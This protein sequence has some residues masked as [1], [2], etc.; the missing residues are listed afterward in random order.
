MNR[1]S[2]LATAFALVAGLACQVAPAAAAAADE[3]SPAEII[4]LVDKAQGD[5]KDLTTDSK[6]VVMEPGATSGREYR[7]VTIS[8]GNEKR[9]VRFLE[10]GDVKGMGMLI[11]GRDTMY[12]LLP[13]FGNRIRRLGTHVKNQGF[14][15]SDVST[16]DMAGGTLADVYD[17]KVVSGSENG[18][19]EW[20]LELTVKPGK[21]AEFPRRFMWVQKDINQITRFE[22]FD[23]KG[24]NVRSSWRS[25]YRKDEG[26]ANH[27]TPFLLR[28]VDHRRN[29]H[30]TEIRML[31]AKVNQNVP[32]DTFTQRA[33]VRGQ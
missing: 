33:L 8:K 13:A 30:V 12:A 7:F 3:P 11:E 26:P 20:K 19:K 9:L 1:R 23:A 18:G 24:T 10:P 5:F 29:D 28:I 16:E 27:Y 4:K 31:S 25:D 17:V 15:G 32:D 22:D 14:M 6:L 2:R 21:E